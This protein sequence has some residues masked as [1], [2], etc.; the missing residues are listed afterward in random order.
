MSM[1]K[2]IDT[3]KM[4]K[5]EIMVVYFDNNSVIQLGGC[6]PTVFTLTVDDSKEFARQHV[7]FAN[8]KDSFHYTITGPNM[9][10][11][12]SKLERKQKEKNY[13]PLSWT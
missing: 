7:L 8:V 13:D 9:V 3:S 11:L 1:S 4:F 5:L 6:F 10:K 2:D 12:N